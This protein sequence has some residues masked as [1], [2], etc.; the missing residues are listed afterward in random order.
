PQDGIFEPANPRLGMNYNASPTLG[1]FLSYGE[2]SRAPAFLELTSA[3]P[4]A[5]C[6]GLQAGAAPDP[7]IQAVKAHSYEAG[8][9]AR[10]LP[11]L[12]TDLSVFRTDVIDDIFAV[13]PTGTVG[14]FFQNIGDTRRQGV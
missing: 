13:S 2:G 5:I 12:E 8:V 10:P 6:P 14:V 3:T 4:A 7:P 9:R 1:F 11:W